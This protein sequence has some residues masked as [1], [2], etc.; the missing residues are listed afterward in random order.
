MNLIQENNETLITLRALAKDVPGNLPGK[1]VHLSTLHRWRQHGLK[2]GEKLECVRV[3][4]RWMNSWEAF[5]RFAERM[6]IS[7]G[8]G[9]NS[10][11]MTE[12][13]DFSR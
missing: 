6:T 4:G 2:N 7:A 5:K 3:G 8:G 1:H 10:A 9:T 13:S 11:V 12:G